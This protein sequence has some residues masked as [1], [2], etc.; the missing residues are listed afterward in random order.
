M[1]S[2][3]GSCHISNL[4]IIHVG[5]LELSTLDLAECR[6]NNLTFYSSKKVR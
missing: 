6:I 4:L 2:G 3:E 5:Q 1:H